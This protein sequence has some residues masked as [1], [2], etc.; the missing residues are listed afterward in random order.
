MSVRIWLASVAAVA[1]IATTRVASADD[2]VECTVV[3]I[4]ATNGKAPA[5]DPELKPLERKLKKAPFTAYNE[6]HQLSR[7]T[8]TLTRSKAESLPLKQGAATVML[9]DKS[10]KRAEL[11]ITMDDAKG[12]RVVD[13]KPAVPLGNDWTMLVDQKDAGAHILALTCK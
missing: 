10:E 3:E 13:A 1:T 5:I 2:T 11:A 12:K 6:F 9:R 7:T 8:K 4:N